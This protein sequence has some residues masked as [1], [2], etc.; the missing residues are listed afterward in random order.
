MSVEVHLFSRAEENISDAFRYYEDQSIGLGEIFIFH[1]EEVIVNISEYPEMYQKV[2]G[3][4]RRGLIH[5]FPYGVYYLYEQ[6]EVI[7]LNVFNTKQD[8][9]SLLEEN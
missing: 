8:I 9:D 6:G 7:V 5:R 4:I 1:L 2:R 3:E